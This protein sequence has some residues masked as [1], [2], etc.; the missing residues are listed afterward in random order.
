MRNMKMIQTCISSCRAGV[1]SKET[2]SKARQQ[3]QVTIS[4]Y[5]TGKAVL[6]IGFSWNRNSWHQ[7][8]L[9]VTPLAKKYNHADNGLTIKEYLLWSWYAGQRLT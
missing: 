7:F 4:S 2:E 8:L 9:Q 6:K 1:K 5:A 3:W